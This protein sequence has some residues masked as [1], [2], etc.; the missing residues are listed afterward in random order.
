MRGERNL[1]PANQEAFARALKLSDTEAEFFGWLVKLG[2]ATSD[3]ERNEAW[4]R[5]STTQR[6]L[7]ARRVEGAAFEC[8]THWYYPAIRELAHRADFIADADWLAAR[9][10]P[11]I[12]PAEAQRALD[13]LFE[14]ELLAR[15]PD[16]RIRVTDATVVTAPEVAGLAVHNYHYGMLARAREAVERFDPEERLLC[17]STL[18]VPEHLLEQVR[19]EVFALHE[20]VL[21]L[22]DR[23]ASADGRVYQLS[24][25]LFPLSDAPESN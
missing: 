16:G 19:Q 9:L 18:A 15:D 25:C 2:Q 1:T 12:T 7:G 3:L 24:V 21:N 8:L 20:R 17:G 14:F 11:T 4:E 6:A 10:R 13:V 5:I 23:E 22:C